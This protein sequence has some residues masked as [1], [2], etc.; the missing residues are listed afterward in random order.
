MSIEITGLDDVIKE[1]SRL[2]NNAEKLS[3]KDS[4]DFS[5]LFNPDFLLKHSSFSSFNELAD[6]SPF[7]INSDKDF[8]AIPDDEWD[9]F[10]KENTDFHNWEEMF[11]EATDE[12]LTK[13]LGL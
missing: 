9:K 10:I 1:L 7:T 13:E 4:V 5:E 8:E 2:E 3:K 11:S 12:W 6:K